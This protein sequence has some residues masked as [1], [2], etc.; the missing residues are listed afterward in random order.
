MELEI[1]WMK[2]M[3]RASLYRYPV[4]YLWLHLTGCF[5][6]I[7]FADFESCFA[8]HGLV[9]QRIG[10][11]HKGERRYY[12]V[13]GGVEG[14]G[15]NHAQNDPT[16]KWG[17]NLKAQVCQEDILSYQLQICSSRLSQ[18]QMKWY[19]CSKQPFKC[20]HIKFWEICNAPKVTIT[21]MTFWFE[22]DLR[23]WELA[24]CFWGRFRNLVFC[25]PLEEVYR[26]H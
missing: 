16:V 2:E 26:T 11:N 18:K 1:L 12:A 24:A 3:K 6:N 5:E 23:L 10:Q 13:G 17:W 9:V 14:W 19:Y 7:I 15:G 22:A 25:A 21:V 20:S 4:W 8:Q